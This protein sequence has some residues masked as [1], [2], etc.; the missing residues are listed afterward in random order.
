MPTSKVRKSKKK[1]IVSNY[2]NL[3]IKR[4]KIIELVNSIESLNKLAET[5]LNAFVSFKLG[6][7]LKDAG[8]SIETYNKVRSEKVKEYGEVVLDAEGKET[9]QY[10]FSIPGTKELTENGKKFVE[11]M[12]A[13]EEEELDIKIPEINIKDLGSVEIEPKYLSIL[14]WLIK[15]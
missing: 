9:D 3:N 12:K 1:Q 5:K 4:M 15:E 6:K 2:Y 10:S 8:A 7:F 11:E 13:I 14:Q